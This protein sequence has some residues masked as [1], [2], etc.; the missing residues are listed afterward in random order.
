MCHYLFLYLSLVVDFLVL[1][2]AFALVS[3]GLA[4]AFALV[5]AGL[6]VTFIL[7]SAGLAVAFFGDSFEP[8]V[9]AMSIILSNVRFCL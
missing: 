2:A 1:A 8:P 4:A 7:V 6:A 3:A 9:S 5:S